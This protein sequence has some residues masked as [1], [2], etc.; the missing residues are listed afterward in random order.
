MGLYLG[1]MSGTSMD[2]IDAALV[3]FDVKPLALLATLARL[4]STAGLKRRIARA[5]R[6]MRSGVA[7]DEIGQIDVA[8]ARAFAAA[9]WRAA[10][11][12]RASM[13]GP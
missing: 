2:A 10:A 1:L 11:R 3:D 5:H 6:R 7:L 12:T 13:P 9:R 4:R 8:L